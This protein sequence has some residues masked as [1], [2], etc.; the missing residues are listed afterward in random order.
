MDLYYAP[1]SPPSRAV[2]LAAEHIGVTF[3]LNIIDILKGEHLTPD[4]EEVSIFLRTRRNDIF[5]LAKLT[6]EIV[7]TW[8]SFQRCT[9]RKKYRFS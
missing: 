2:L 9:R 3:N 4:Y 8:I 5:A 1:Y 6:N 7:K